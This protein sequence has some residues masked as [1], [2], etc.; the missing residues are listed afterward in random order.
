[1]ETL[2]KLLNAE[3]DYRM[4]EETMDM[5]LGLMTEKRYKRGE[6]VIPYGVFDNNIYVVKEGIV[7][8]AYFDGFNEMTLAFC[9]P[10]TLIISYYAF[11]KDNPSFSKYEACCP[12]TV[13]K[14][15][16][17][18]FIEL[19]NSSHDFAKWM[20]HMSLEQ[21]MFFERKREVMNGDAKERLESLILNRPEI[22]ENVSSR[23]IASYIGITPRYLSKLKK[24]IAQELKK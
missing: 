14:I 5:L 8:I 9:L 12:S 6:S 11:C 23:V 4:K 10:G 20:M 16:K 1:M 18:K 17:S 3:C 7:R 15:P 24:E 22:M 2:K 19:S 21:L 13:M